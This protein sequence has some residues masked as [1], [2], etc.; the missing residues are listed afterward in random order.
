MIRDP[1]AFQQRSEMERTRF[2]EKL[3]FREAAFLLREILR[4]GSRLKDPQNDRPVSYD[5][6]LRR[7]A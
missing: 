5:R 4:L 1:K 3:T 6:L 2:L 7:Q